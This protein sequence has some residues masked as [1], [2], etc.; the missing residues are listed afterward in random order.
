ME[1]PIPPEPEPTRWASA[2]FAGADLA[3][4]RRVRRVVRIAGAWADRPGRSIPAPFEDRYDIKAAYH[5]FDHAD[6]TPERLQAGHRG[7]VAEALRQRG[8]SLLIEDT[9]V[10][11]YPGRRPVPGLGTV[12]YSGRGQ[13]GFHL[14]TVLA[15]RWPG[16]VR[17]DAHG[18]RP[19]LEVLGLADQQSDVRAPLP[20]GTTRRRPPARKPTDPPK[21]WERATERVG[22]A[23]EGAAVRWVRVC[24]R[25][26]D[27][28]EFLRSCQ[29]ARRG[30]VVRAARDRIVRDPATG[31]PDGSLRRQVA[32]S[33]AL[34]QFVLQL[35]SRPGR[36]ARSAMLSVSVT[37]VAP[38]APRRP[39][40]AADATERLTC[41]AV[42]VW[43]EHPPEG[44]EP[45]EWV[46]MCDAP[47]A[48]RDAAI[49]R[50]S[51]Y[52]ARWLVETCQA[53]CT[54]S[55][56]WCS[57]PGGGYDQRRRAA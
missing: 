20:A 42:R 41:T 21:A 45:L 39:G 50:A 55:D 2:H 43:E 10:I 8:T 14:H 51:Q 9:T 7:L 19:A 40:R 56:R 54:S 34:G 28:D 23:P 30:F 24:D 49:G 17:P 53:D 32:A 36:A 52:S 15:A 25:E 3:D 22:P 37:P 27:I 1:R 38:V 16:Q 4:V 33:A 35:R 6:A 26:A 46:L 57:T 44:V 5:L 11:S 13:T 29:R 18:R 12:G 48:G 31:R 47:V